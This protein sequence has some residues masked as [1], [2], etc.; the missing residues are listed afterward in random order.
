M[1]TVQEK[2]EAAEKAFADAVLANDLVYKAIVKALEAE[3]TA[4]LPQ[5]KVHLWCP[6]DV[7]T[8]V[9]YGLCISLSSTTTIEE[10]DMSFS[11]FVYLPVVT[12]FDTDASCAELSKEFS[13]A[14]QAEAKAEIVTAVQDF[15]KACIAMSEAAVNA[16]AFVDPM[17][18]TPTLNS[19]ESYGVVP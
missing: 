17:T 9:Q 13:L 12:G 18:H 1:N 2:F 15:L 11:R 6:S 3:G 7:S 8:E 14:V 10:L 4:E 19:Y 16:G 5:F